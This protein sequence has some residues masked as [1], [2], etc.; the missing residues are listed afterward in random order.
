MF[1]MVVVYIFSPSIDFERVARGSSPV[2]DV[3][4]VGRTALHLACAQGSALVLDVLLEHKAG[5]TDRK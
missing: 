1:E 2:N 3:D 4:A 5:C